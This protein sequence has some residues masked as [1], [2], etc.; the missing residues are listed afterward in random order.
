MRLTSVLRSLA[1]GCAW[2]AAVAAAANAQSLGDV[3]SGIELRYNGMATMQSE[4]SQEIIHAGSRRLRHVGTV[5]LLRPQKM[6]WD[7][8]SPEGQL[9]IGDG[10]WLRMY[11]PLTNQVSTVEMSPNADMRAPLG[12]LLGRMRLRRQFRNLRLRA[13][14]GEQALIG[15]GLTGAE[16][17]RDVE[18]YYSPSDYRLTLVRLT[19]RDESITEFRFKNEKRNPR[20]DES[21]FV[22]EAPAGAEI[23]PE[24]KLGGFK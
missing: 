9:L 8:S 14:N 5:K 22:F 4:F 17:Y 18:F 21:L 2:L 23:L 19:G 6:R 20:L 12:F 11:N 1:V 24:S 16:L 3:I 15:D 10:F 13:I 7:Y